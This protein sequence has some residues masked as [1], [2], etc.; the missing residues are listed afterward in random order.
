M[1]PTLGC[2][3]ILA[4][5]LS[6]ASTMR[7]EVLSDKRIIITTDWR[8]FKQ[9]CRRRALRVML[10]ALCVVRTLMILKVVVCKGAGTWLKRGQ[11]V[12]EVPLQV[13]AVVT[14]RCSLGGQGREVKR[15]RRDT[16]L[17]KASK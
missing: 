8:K 1:V 16:V 10:T 11:L 12:V 3:I 5:F 9:I 14:E 7:L 13:G 15:S 2:H 6:L 4:T 17:E